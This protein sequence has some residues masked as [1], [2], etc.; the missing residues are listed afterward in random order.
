MKRTDF[1]GFVASFANQTPSSCGSACGSSE[2]KKEETPSA[3]GSA[4]GAQ[5]PKKEDKPS[6]CGSACGAK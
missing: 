2:P 6:A 4:C 1:G 3:C 5:E